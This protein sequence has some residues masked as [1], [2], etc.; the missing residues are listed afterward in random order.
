MIPSGHPAATLLGTDAVFL[1]PTPR[2]TVTGSLDALDVLDRAVLTRTRLVR[3]SD[4]E[5]AAAMRGV[6]FF[7][8]PVPPLLLIAEAAEHGDRTRV[9]AVLT[10]G[11]HLDV[12]GVLLGPWPAGNTVAVARNGLTSSTGRSD[13]VTSGAHPADVGRLTVLE[14]ARAADLILIAIE[15]DTGEAQPAS[16]TIQ[17]ATLAPPPTPSA[18]MAAVAAEQIVADA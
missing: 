2:L 15:A 6:G 5:D 4:T 18:P 7:D 9:A 16:A 1:G 8:E 13:T 17:G 11:E 10:Q 3:D 12:H 14:P